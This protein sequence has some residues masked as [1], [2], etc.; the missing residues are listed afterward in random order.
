M[1]ITTARVVNSTPIELV[2]LSFEVI[3]DNLKTSLD[4]IDN[5]EKINLEISKAFVKDLSNSLDM[6]YEISKNLKALYTYTLERLVSAEI[7]SDNSRMKKYIEEAISV[8]EKL[9]DSFN[10]VSKMDLNDKRVM[11]NTD[12]IYS[13]LTYGMN[14]LNETVVGNTNRGLKA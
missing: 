11:E 7:T 6:K 2:T 14:G 12:A 4:Q 10:E 13:G 8:M 1:E 5:N 9:S 3:L